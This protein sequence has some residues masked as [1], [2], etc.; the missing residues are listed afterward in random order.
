MFDRLLFSVGFD[1]HANTERQWVEGKIAAGSGN[2][3]AQVVNFWSDR[4]RAFVLATLQSRV[5]QVVSFVESCKE[6]L[7]AAFRAIDRKSV[8]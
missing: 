6:A 2:S 5:N 8:V 7:S 3:N 4:R 1:P